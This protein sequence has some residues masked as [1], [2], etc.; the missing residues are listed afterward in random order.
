MSVI[1][2]EY[3]SHHMSLRY[4]MKNIPILQHY[5]NILQK[6]ISCIPVMDIP[7]KVWWFY[8]FF[9]L[10]ALVLKHVSGELPIG[11]GD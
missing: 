2:Y 11:I 8:H 9:T 1:I 10:Y 5:P 7:E 3:T 6:R 4:V